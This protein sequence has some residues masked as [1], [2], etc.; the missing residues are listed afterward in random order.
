[1]LEDQHPAIEQVRA[2]ED[3]P[4]GVEHRGGLVQHQA[5]VEKVPFQI[6]L[7]AEVQV[8]VLQLPSGEGHPDGGVRAD[9]KKHLP[10]AG[11][12]HLVLHRQP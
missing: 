3:L 12:G 2:Q 5:V 7:I 11:V 4:A 10:G 1:M 6:L 8:I 9:G